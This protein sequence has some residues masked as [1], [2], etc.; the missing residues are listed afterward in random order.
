MS[1]PLLC[2]SGRGKILKTEKMQQKAEPGFAAEMSGPQPCTQLPAV[3][4][5]SGELPPRFAAQAV[6]PSAAWLWASTGGLQPPQSGWQSP[7]ENQTS[8]K[9]L[10]C[11]CLCRC[12]GARQTGHKHGLVHGQ[13][14]QS[15]L[16]FLCYLAGCSARQ[17]LRKVP[18]GAIARS[19]FMISPLPS[20]LDLKG[21][22]RVVGSSCVWSKPC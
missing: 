8:P 11:L 2:R 16:L 9:L 21:S 1:F 19:W 3:C 5:V 6:F 13:E 10:P 12:M 4:P 20:P 22:W 14:R 17:A 15:R 7:G 18:L